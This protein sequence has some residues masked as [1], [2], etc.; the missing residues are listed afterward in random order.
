MNKIQRT[1]IE[2]CV[3]INVRQQEITTYLVELVKRHA[4][5]DPN[6]SEW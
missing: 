6:D 3:T 1:K 2:T 5:K 4:I